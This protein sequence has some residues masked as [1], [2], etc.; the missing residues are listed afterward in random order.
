MRIDGRKI[1]KSI[2]EDLRERVA[3]LKKKGITAHLAIILVGHDPASEA[4]VNQKVKKTEEI[5]AK[6]TVVRRESGIRNQEL[7]EL[8]EAFN[9]EP[10]VHGIIVQ[11]PLPEHIDVE[12]IDR[13]VDPAKDVDGFCP[14]TPFTMPLAVAVIKILETVYASTPGVD[15]RNFQKWL[16]SKLFTVIGK[17]R[18]GGG[19]IIKSLKA[20]GVAPLI[21]DSRTTNSKRITK[22]ADIVISAVGKPNVVASSMLKRGMILISVGLH[23]GTD[24]K[25]HGDYE[26]D[27]IKDIASFYTPTPGGVGP[28]NVAML[29][30]NL[31]E[32]TEVLS[33]RSQPS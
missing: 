31:V 32:A 23:K 21:I 10:T 11:R 13:A 24:G 19:P 22:N 8:I 2:L 9:E 26:E 7:E 20:L 27:D 4:Y 29:L 6:A 25:L 33:R 12:T 30:K 15:A 5:G 3:T 1:A 28:V 16:Q 14:Q 17:G 18:T